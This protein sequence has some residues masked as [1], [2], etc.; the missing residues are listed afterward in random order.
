[1]GASIVTELNSA[2]EGLRH[3]QEKV[4]FIKRARHQS[5][6]LHPKLMFLIECMNG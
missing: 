4:K 5:M 2:V 1:M 3:V 6:P